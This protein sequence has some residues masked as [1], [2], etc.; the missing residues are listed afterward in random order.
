MTNVNTLSAAQDYAA[1]GFC[2]IP[3]WHGAKNPVTKNGLHD[4]SS[5]RNKI[6]HW[7]SGSKHNIAIVTGEKSQVAVIDIDTYAGGDLTAL[8]SE[9]GTLPTTLEAKTRAGGRHLFFRYPADTI[10]SSH[11]GKIASHVD[12]KAQGGYVVAAPSWV[13]ADEKGPAG[14]YEWT[15]DS[16]IA[17]LPDS[18][19][20]RWASLGGA[21]SGNGQKPPAGSYAIPERIEEG[22]RNSELLRY[23]SHLRGKGIPDELILEIA[24]DFNRSRCNPPM[25]DDE[26]VSVAKRYQKPADDD[27]NAWPEPADIKESLPPVTPF[28]PQWLPHGLSDWALDI[29]DRLNCPVDFPAVTMITALGSALGSRIY[30][31]P[32]SRDTWKVPANVWA[33]LVAPPGAMKSPVL[34]EGLRPLVA[35]DKKAADA[36][37][38]AMKKFTFDKAVYEGQFRKAA[39]NNGTPPVPPKEPQMTRHL[40]NDTTYEM[41]V[42]IAA[43]NPSGILVL[44]DEL[45]GWFHSLE[46]ENQKEAR[47]LYLTGWNGTDGYATDRIGRGHVRADQVV[48]SLLGS[49][50]P[51]V[52]RGLIQDAVSGGSGDDGLVQRFQLMVFPDTSPDWHKVD[53]R[54]DHA[55]EDAYAKLIEQFTTLDCTA[56]G[57]NFE[58]DGTPYLPFSAAAQNV[59]DEWQQKLENRIRAVNTEEH[60]VMLAHL[61]KYRSLFPKLALILHLADGGVGPISEKAAAR[62][63][64]WVAYLES[65]ARRIYHTATNRTM[66]CAAT[67]ANKIRADR[68]PTVFT[69]SDVLLKEWANLRKAEEVGMAVTV[70]RDMRWLA[71]TEDRG[72]GGRP[73]ERYQ[74]NPKVNRAV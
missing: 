16:S 48:I 14:F 3:C 24:R 28:N 72:T 71:V 41:L 29:A 56:I 26:V 5:D 67:L 74:I 60:A 54:P 55:A 58:M 45:A 64:F 65:H 38:T 1:R 30:V 40:V 70:L 11:N 15:N 63:Y 51:N 66:Q 43:A 13:E 36:Y 59:F 21:E 35:M 18:W 17:E 7:F 39:S 62:A 53:R 61:G 19:R 20:T 34:R 47:G 22:K 32:Y 2:V 25:D 33:A 4:A 6:H 46:K 31:K 57:A 52:L 8:E 27:P 73:A 12:L 37:A 69:R 50:Q 49:I 23:C 10:L 42:V 68:L 44:R 9:L